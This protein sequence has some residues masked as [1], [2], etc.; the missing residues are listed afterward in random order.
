MSLRGV[1]STGPTATQAG[2]NS[3]SSSSSSSSNSNPNHHHPTANS[4]SEQQRRSQG[5]ELEEQPASGRDLDLAS[6][7]AL[8][9]SLAPRLRALLAHNPLRM[10]LGGKLVIMQP[11]PAR[12]HV[13]YAEPDLR[14]SDD[15]RRLR[16]VCG[17]LVAI[18]FFFLTTPP[19][20]PLTVSFPWRGRAAYVAMI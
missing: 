20:H 18:F 19:P 8:L 17:A 4:N 16:A 11:D 12:A 15:G 3:S 10:P 14:S 1:T 7:S 6:A 13:L 9:A 2:L 5:E